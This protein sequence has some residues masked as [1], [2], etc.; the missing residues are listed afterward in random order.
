LNEVVYKLIED[1]QKW[2]TERADEIEKEKILGLATISKLEILSQ[3][4]FRNSNPA[5]FGVRVVA[6]KIKTGIPLIDNNGEEIARVKG[7]QVEKTS[8]NEAK[9]GQEL[10]ISLPGTNFERQLKESKYLYVDISERQF[11]DFKKNKDLLSADELKTL[12]EIAA[13]KRK[14]NMSWG[15]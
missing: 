6:G 4:V 13:I 5:I 14:K 12:E 1:L 2:R 10:A 11:K 3:Y 8:V 15:M 7:L 9:P